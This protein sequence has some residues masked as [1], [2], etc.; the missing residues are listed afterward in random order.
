M[1]NEL[2]SGVAHGADSSSFNDWMQNTQRGANGQGTMSTNVKFKNHCWDMNVENF[3]GRMIMFIL[4]S[5]SFKCCHKLK[6]PF[7]MSS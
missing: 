4:C 7:L 6:D 5:L 2:C 3:Y 1:V